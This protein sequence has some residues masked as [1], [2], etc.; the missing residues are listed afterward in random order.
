MIRELTADLVKNRTSSKVGRTQVMI[1]LDLN[2]DMQKLNENMRLLEICRNDWEGLR[3]FRTRRRRARRYYRGNQW[4]DYVKNPNGE[5]YIT[6][7]VYLKQ[8]GKV[9]LK[10][11]QIRQLVK[12]LIGQYRSNPSKAVVI[13]R[14][15][16]D[17]KVSEMLT[18]AL[19]AAEQTNKISTLDARMF[20]EFAVSGAIIQKLSYKYWKEKNRPDLWIENVNPNRMFFNGDLLDPRHTDIRRIGEIQDV[21]M[22][23][24]IATFAKTKAEENRIRQLYR[25]VV[26]PEF[27]YQRGLD[28]TKIDSLDFFIPR[29]PSM[30]RLIEVWELKMEWRTYAHDLMDGSYSIVKE[31]LKEIAK[32]NAERIKFGRALGMADEEILLIEAEEKPEQF[33]QVKFLTPYGNVL[34]EAETPYKH[35]SHPYAITLFPL[36]DGEV[37]GF[38]EDVIDQQRYINRLIILMDFIINA[39]AK[40]V[41][42]VPED[43]IP[44]GMTVQDFADEWTKFNG[45]IV[46]KP[47]QHQQMPEQIASKSTNIGISELLQLEMNL[48]SQISGV[49]EAIQGMR[50]TAG[51]PSSL[52][53]QE[54]QNATLNT[55]DYMHTFNQ[56]IQERDMKALKIICQYYDSPRYL[57]VAGRQYNQE[58]KM[59]NPALVQDIDFELVVTSGNDT[60]VFRQ[61]VDDTLI[62]MLE[63]QMIDLQMYLE[64]TSMPF[65]DKLLESLKARQAA[66]QSG[67][68]A[69]QLPGD[70]M[71][72]LA[73]QASPQAMAMLGPAMTRDIPAYSKPAG[74]GSV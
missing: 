19:Q 53:A 74:K 20:E 12:N 60:P 54:T 44:K 13:A 65:A 7:E 59:W 4:G 25:T 17:A 22:D 48:L 14:D 72:A 5:G 70:A 52:Y 15:R 62:K 69:P 8:Q 47:S 45:V 41:L 43:V 23:E 18:N 28:A 2:E 63:S 31:T 67:E 51:T 61:I 73:G 21:P 35:E 10:Q 3:D 36:L 56:F 27:L 32:M 39:S 66:V 64:N 33:W 57:A 1:P 6:E 9:P 30:C 49:H 38:V 71:A 37:W 68:M 55:L 42:L 50:P 11:N 16:D 58:A 24:L 34:F 29:D 40:G 26:T 46:Y